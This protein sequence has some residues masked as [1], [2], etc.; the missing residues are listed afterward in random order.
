MGFF[1][2]AYDLFAISIVTKL[3]GRIYFNVDG[4]KKPGTLPPDVNFFVVGVAPAGTICM[5]ADV[6]LVQ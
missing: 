5:H 2:D 1:T 4:A 6:Y 3:L